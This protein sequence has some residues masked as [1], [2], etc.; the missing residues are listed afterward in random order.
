VAYPVSYSSDFTEDRSRLSTFFRYLFAIPHIIVMM[1]YGLAAFFSVVVAWFSIVFTGQYPAALYAF[2][3]GALRYFTRVQ[4]YLVLATDA[5][6]P[7]GGGEAPEYPVRLAIGPPLPEYDRMKALFRIILAIPIMIIGYALN[8]VTTIASIISW[9]WIVITGKQNDGLHS[10][11]NLGVSYNARAA[12]YYCLLTETW[13]PFT[14]EGQLSSGGT[15]AGTLQQATAP[16]P[17]APEAPAEPPRPRVEGLP[18]PPPP[19]DTTPPPGFTS[20]DPLG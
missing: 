15:P 9:F 12:G 7:F 8:I 5:Y 6:P 10:A 14:D 18:D 13:P 2:N 19:S 4:A 11:I 16:P 1:F 3:A 20:G 17:A